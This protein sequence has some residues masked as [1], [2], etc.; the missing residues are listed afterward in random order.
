MLH[1]NLSAPQS[2]TPNFRS[3]TTRA[4]TDRK[5]KYEGVRLHD[6]ASATSRSLAS[7]R[8]ATQTVL[9]AFGV[10]L[11]DKILWLDGHVNDV[12]SIMIEFRICVQC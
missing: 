5:G 9:A 10:F 4:E 12:W 6:D 11:I 1:A 3:Q 7:F 2:S 8:S